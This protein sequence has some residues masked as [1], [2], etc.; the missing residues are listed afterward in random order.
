MNMRKTVFAN[1]LAAIFIAFT[2]PTLAI[3]A[4]E[5]IT[6]MDDTERGGYVT[7]LVDMLAYTQYLNGNDVRGKC[8]LDWYYRT[9]AI[10]AKV[11]DYFAAYPDNPPEAIMIVMTKRVCPEEPTVRAEN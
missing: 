5:V 1:A 3:T 9:E 7:G 11:A 6:G 2:N 10:P 8:I 4:G